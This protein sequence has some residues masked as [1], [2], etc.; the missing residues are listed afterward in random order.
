MEKTLFSRIISGEIPCHKIYEDERTFAFLDIYPVQPGHILVVPKNPVQFVWDLQS[1]DYQAVMATAQRLALHQRTVL[2]VPYISSRVVGIDVPHAHVHLIP[3]S[4]VDQ[5]RT[6]PD[7]T[8][9][10]DHTAFAAM[11]DKLRYN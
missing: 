1:D 5:L 10:P 9:E 6:E 8:R 3:F 11:A 7:R 2:G 4:V